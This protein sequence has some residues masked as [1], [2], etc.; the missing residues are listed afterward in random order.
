MR[1]SRHPQAIVLVESETAGLEQCDVDWGS[2]ATS[3]RCVRVG[4]HGGVHLDSE[5]REWG[6]VPAA[7]MW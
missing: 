6:W 7:E 2:A 1:D 5:G 4:G 3:Q